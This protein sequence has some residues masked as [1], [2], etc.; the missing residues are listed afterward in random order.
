MRE[1]KG[2]WI[3]LGK[4]EAEAYKALSDLRAPNRNMLA[5]FER[6]ERERLPKKAKAT[7]DGQRRQLSNLKSTFGHMEPHKVRPAHI[8]AFHDALGQTAPVSANRHLALLSDVFKFALRI[9][10]VDLNPCRCLGRHE[11]CPRD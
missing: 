8:A 11:E 3:R 2:K 6:Y 7:Q 10:A 5:I 4:T 9:G 1:P